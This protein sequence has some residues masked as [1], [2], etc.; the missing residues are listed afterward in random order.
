MS[1]LLKNTYK[2]VNI[3]AF[4]RKNTIKRRYNAAIGYAAGLAFTMR[5]DSCSNANIAIYIKK[6][7]MHVGTMH[8]GIHTMHVRK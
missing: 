7:S 2:Y 6:I 4:S 5:R 3:Y 8:V 1:N